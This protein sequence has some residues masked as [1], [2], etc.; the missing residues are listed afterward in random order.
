VSAARRTENSRLSGLGREELK[1]RKRAEAEARKK[2]AQAL[3]PLRDTHSRLEREL[4]D[5]LARQGETERLLALPEVYADTARCAELLKEFH[6]LQQRAED[7][8][9]RL[10]ASEAAVAAA[11]TGN[12]PEGRGFKP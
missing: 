9:E 5:T 4:E 11:S 10:A 3:K 2:P 12:L 7:L 1:R 8:L 6:V